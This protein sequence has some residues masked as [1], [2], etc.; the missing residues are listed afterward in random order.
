MMMTVLLWKS[1]ES[2]CEILSS[3]KLS[4][5]EV[6]SSRMMILGIFEKYLCYC[7]SLLL[8]TGETNSSLADLCVHPY[9]VDL[10]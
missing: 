2:D 1:A 9:V 3:L 8:S 6:G 10:R 7:K 4:S 5:A